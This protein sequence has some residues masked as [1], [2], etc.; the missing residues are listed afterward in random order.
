MGALASHAERGESD[1]TDDD[2][3]DWLSALLIAGVITFCLIM[4]AAAA[5]WYRR[6][7]KAQSAHAAIKRTAV[8][9]S[10][11]HVSPREAWGE[12]KAEK[13][14]DVDADAEMNGAI[15][16]LGSEATAGGVTFD[17]YAYAYA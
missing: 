9:S 2:P 3:S 8:V 14:V 11:E 13:S 12:S 7:T 16:A 10:N 1:K 4:V 6:Y 15:R 17:P 5:H